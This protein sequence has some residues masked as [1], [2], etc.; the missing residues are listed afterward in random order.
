M[1]NLLLIAWQHIDLINDDK[2]NS[3]LQSNVSDALLVSLAVTDACLS[4]IIFACLYLQ[5]ELFSLQHFVAFLSDCS[6]LDEKQL[7]VQ[8]CSQKLKEIVKTVFLF[9]KEIAKMRW[10]MVK[11]GERWW[12]TGKMTRTAR[13]PRKVGETTEKIWKTAKT[14]KGSKRIK[15]GRRGVAYVGQCRY[16]NLKRGAWDTWA[17][18]TWDWWCEDF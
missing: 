10:K 5:T 9:S 14:S 16:Q 12:K 8:G 13:K 6:Q 18:D 4:A 15:K 7:V 1:G 3:P 2:C 17:W 11:D